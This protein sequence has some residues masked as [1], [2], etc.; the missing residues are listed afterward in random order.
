MKF[1]FVER[2]RT[3]GFIVSAAYA[4]AT[5]A[6]VITSNNRGVRSVNLRRNLVSRN[7]QHK[8]RRARK[9][10][11]IWYFIDARV[12]C[13]GPGYRRRYP[14]WKFAICETRH[15]VS[16]S[17]ALSRQVQAVSPIYFPLQLSLRIERGNSITRDKTNISSIYRYF[18]NE[19]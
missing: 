14:S 16:H 7:R 1:Q 4:Q 13:N 9:T 10:R 6:P 12:Q 17:A 8:S 11:S 18:L 19:K 2:Q 5:P 3:D 15:F